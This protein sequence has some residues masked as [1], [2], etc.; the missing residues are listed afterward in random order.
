MRDP[1]DP[2]PQKRRH[3][4]VPVLVLALL[5]ALFG[6]FDR[7]EQTTVELGTPSRIVVISE[8][9]PVRV[10]QGPVSQVT[11]RD[12]WAFSRPEVEIEARQSD[13]LIRITCG[14]LMPCRSS[15]DLEVTG[16]PDLLI[17][18]DG[19]VDV[20]RFDGKLTVLSADGGVALG[21]V[22][23]SVRVGANDSVT[24][25]GIQTELLDISSSGDV[26]LWFGGEI[27]QHRI[28][29][30]SSDGEVRPTS[31]E[32]VTIEISSDGDAERSVAIRSDGEVSLLL[33][34]KTDP[35]GPDEG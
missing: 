30:L 15:I 12:S 21:A 27:V 20:D 14:S 23:G 28:Q 5:L 8:A 31:D 22:S 24:G 33:A 3:W 19:F 13:I 25:A 6:L 34:P 26:Q 10:S 4:I 29:V 11:H 35:I 32:T 2:R 18:A 17:V 9:G 16:A 7:S 1:D